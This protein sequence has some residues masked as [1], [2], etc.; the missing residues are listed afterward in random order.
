MEARVDNL[1]HSVRVKRSPV[2]SDCA[3][4]VSTCESGSCKS[5]HCCGAK[6]L[7]FACEVSVAE[8]LHVPSQVY[9][10]PK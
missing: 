3:V 2:G 10:C 9:V 1:V 5:G 8:V 4:R 6:G 7:S